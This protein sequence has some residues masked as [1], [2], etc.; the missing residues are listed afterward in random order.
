MAC[1]F[2][3]HFE[4]QQVGGLCLALYAENANRKSG[5]TKIPCFRKMCRCEGGS[6]KGLFPWGHNVSMLWGALPDQLAEMAYAF[7][8]PVA[9]SEYAQR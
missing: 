7:Y 4:H 1:G 8:V 6:S 3:S 2:K 9:E 5:E